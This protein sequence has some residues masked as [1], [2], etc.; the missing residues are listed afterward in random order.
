MTWSS[1]LSGGTNN[2]STPVWLKK[3]GGRWF[4]CGPD[5]TELPEIMLVRGWQTA[6]PPNFPTGSYELWLEPEHTDTLSY[7]EICIPLFGTEGYA[8]P[9]NRF[10]E[11]I[12]NDHA[13]LRVDEIPDGGTPSFLVF[14][15]VGGLDTGDFTVFGGRAGSN[16][17]DQTSSWTITERTGSVEAG[18]YALVLNDTL[19]LA[20]TVGWPGPYTIEVTHPTSGSLRLVYRGVAYDPYDGIRLGLTALPNAAAQAA[21]GLYTRGTGAGQIN[22]DA[23]GRIDANLLRW[24]SG[25]PASLNGSGHVLSAAQS[26]ATDAITAASIAAGAIDYAT[27]AADAASA[28]G[29]VRYESATAGG[30]ST[31]TLDAGASAV[32][33][34]Y[35]NTKIHIASGTG[36]GQTRGYSSYVGS[37]LVYTVDS[38]WDIAPTAGSVFVITANVAGGDATEANQTTILANLAAVKTK[39]DNLPSD[40]ADASDITTQFGVVNA[41]ISSVDSILTNRLPAALVGGR[42]DSYIGAM[43]A[44]VLT[45]AATADDFSTEINA[46]T[47]A[48][49]ST[50]QGDV[51]TLISGVTIASLDAAALLAIED[52]VWDALPASHVVAGSYGEIGARPTGAVVVDGGNTALTFKT[53]LASADNNSY[54]DTWC[55]FLSGALAGQAHKVVSYDGTTKFLTFTSAFTGAPADTDRFLIVNK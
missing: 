16:F 30:A 32:D 6:D 20:S 9:V 17:S 26:I 53:N 22:Q 50:L 19:S 44:N 29:V 34:F 10:Y 55:N 31:I 46:T 28:L 1:F 23:D 3:S 52:I 51:T 7:I 35:I 11:I 8:D 54:R 43:G 38:A 4:D 2:V 48:A 5:G 45:G 40:P 39:T 37:T 14:F 36:A 25:N 18:W 21:G 42:M 13:V 49:I 33:N 24:K 27:L 12:E 15:G 47:L 41:N